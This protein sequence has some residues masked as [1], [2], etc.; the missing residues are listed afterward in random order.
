[1]GIEMWAL[2]AQSRENFQFLVKKFA[3]KG[4]IPLTDFYKIRRGGGSL[5]TTPSRQ[6]SPL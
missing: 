1:M 4:R 3:P 2:V 6:I 5:S